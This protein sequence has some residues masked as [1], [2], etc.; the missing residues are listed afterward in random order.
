MNQLRATTEISISEL[1][2]LP[3]FRVIAG[4]PRGF[5][6]TIGT[7]KVQRVG[8]SLIGHLDNLVRTRIQLL[9]RTEM[10]YLAKQDPAQRTQLFQTLCEADI[11][12]IVITAG[13]DIPHEIID[14]CDKFGVALLAT[15][16]ES[17]VATDELNQILSS[18]YAPRE[19]RHAALVDVHG[20]GVLL[21]GKSGIGKSEI[22]LELISRGHRLVA[23][24][25]V[26]C[27]K[28]GGNTVVGHSPK[29]T[30]HHMEIRGLGIIN[31]KDLYGVAAVR[32]RK[33]IEL[34]VELVEWD[35]LNEIDRLGLEQKRVEFSEVSVP[36][37]SLPVRPGR[38]LSLIIEVAARN[39][40]L[41]E[42]GTHS[43]RAFAMQLS[44]HIEQA[45]ENWT[46]PPSMASEEP[47]E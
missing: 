39:R 47:D 18:W 27:E 36:F 26:I 21:L 46:D 6:R 17:T 15:D 31:I 4:G 33:R 45:E 3:N 30:R 10:S 34:A 43:A 1:A 32:A 11:P 24:D 12:A 14:V 22:A 42:Q 20:V 19:V 38:S 16:Q 28:T 35:D 23:D 2:T 8:L 37:I 5:S 13:E 44:E 25:V 29:L 9:G 7:P 41:Q 40:L